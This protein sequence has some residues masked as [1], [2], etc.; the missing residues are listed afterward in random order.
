MRGGRLLDSIARARRL[1]RHE[2][3]DLLIATF[4]LAKAR[5]RLAFGI[6][7][8]ILERR[9]AAYRP[10]DRALAIR[11]VRTAIERASLRVPWRSN[12]LVQ[13]VASRNWLRRLGL[14]ANLLIGVRE[15]HGPSEAHAWL[16]CDG[17]VVVGGDIRGYVP[18]AGL[19][20]A[21]GHD[22]S[23]EADSSNPAA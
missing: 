22:H 4:E 15:Q 16:I 2:W 21:K 11:R 17:D 5:V 6:E 13:A 10:C 19:N 9:P 8:I 7:Q 1:S 14:E 3:L 12:C 20:D 18:F 23:A